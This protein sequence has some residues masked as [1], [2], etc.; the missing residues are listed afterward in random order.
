MVGNGNVDLRSCSQTTRRP[1]KPS[2]GNQ[3]VGFDQLQLPAGFNQSGCV[4]YGTAQDRAANNA[5]MGEDASLGRRMDAT[6]FVASSEV[7]NSHGDPIDVV[8]NM[9]ATR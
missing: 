3:L 9:W 6:G 5:Q 7:K 4:S 8:V 2:G 1:R